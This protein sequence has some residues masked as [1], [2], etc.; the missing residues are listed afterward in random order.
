[1]EVILVYMIIMWFVV[2]NGIFTFNLQI[3]FRDLANCCLYVTID[4]GEIY[5]KRC[6]LE[7]NASVIK[8]SYNKED[9]F[10]VIDNANNS[11][12][13]FP[14]YYIIT[15]CYNNFELLFLL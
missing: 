4:A 13:S 12:V 11:V 6:N 5:N 10:F 1:M 2:M 3:I 14:T 8:F 15:S 9:Y 7:F